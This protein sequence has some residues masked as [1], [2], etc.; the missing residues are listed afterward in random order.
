MLRGPR[1]RRR[2]AVSVASSRGPPPPLLRRATAPPRRNDRRQPCRQRLGDREPEVF[3]C[4][5][6]DEAVR[7]RECALLGRA[8]HVADERT[9]SRSPS[10]SASA[11]S[12]PR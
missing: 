12:S 4:G 7:L 11:T 9:R 5:W 2:E 1:D 6:E 8:L 3:V 10:C